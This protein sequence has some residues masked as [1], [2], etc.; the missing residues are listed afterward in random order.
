LLAERLMTPTVIGRGGREFFN[1][2][3]M[4]GFLLSV[5]HRETVEEIGFAV[6][7]RRNP[8]LSPRQG[9]LPAAIYSFVFLAWA[10]NPSRRT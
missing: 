6:S 5:R 8:V 9:A 1:P 10:H 7:F 3:E 2:P 4:V